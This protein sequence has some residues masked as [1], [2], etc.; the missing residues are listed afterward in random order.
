MN[1]PDRSVAELLRLD[2]LLALNI[3]DTPPEE[4]YDRLTRMAV[5]M[6]D[7]PIALVSISAA[8]QQ[9]YKSS[10]GLAARHTPR[11]LSFCTHAIQQHDIFIVADALHDTRFAVIP[12]VLTD[13]IRFYAGCPLKSP[14]GH[15]LGTLCIMDYKPR[16]LHSD[17]M[18]ALLDLAAMVES[19][20][21]AVQLATLDDITGIAN[22]RGFLLFAQHSLALCSR[23]QLPG[24]LVFLDLDS[25]SAGS[26]KEAADRT[27]KDFAEILKQTFRQADCYGRIGS[28]EFAVFLTNTTRAQA[29]NIVARFGNQLYEYNQRHRGGE[30][31]EYTS[32]LVEFE[33]GNH[34]DI[35]AMLKEG[36]ALMHQRRER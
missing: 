31:I 29:E 33:P 5:R 28:K 22:R 17:D 11:E 14:D 2:A 20:L 19:E 16:D 9:W 26:G 10:I 15:I 13:K 35:A 6:F 23:Q 32:G 4:R 3:L 1:K 36:A 27:L 24:T 21:A 7:T 8:D 25:I 18:S 30:F 34:H 12:L